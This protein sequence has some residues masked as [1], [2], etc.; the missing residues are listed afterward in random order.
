MKKLQIF[1]GLLDRIYPGR[2]TSYAIIP[3]SIGAAVKTEFPEV[4]ESVRIYNFI[5]DNGNFLLR[6]GDKLFEEKR[7]WQQ[8][9][10]SFAFLAANY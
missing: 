3:Q 10:I 1:T 2:V 7:V 9:Q 6:I 5:G 8:T 4:K